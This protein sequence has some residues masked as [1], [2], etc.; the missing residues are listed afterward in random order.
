MLDM[1]KSQMGL[2]RAV[3]WGKE[4]LIGCHMRRWAHNINSSKEIAK[5]R[6]SNL[7]Y[8]IFIYKNI[9]CFEIL[10]YQTGT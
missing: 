7:S 2:L 9:C 5:S 1:N 6:I 4:Y 8:E 10:M 3:L